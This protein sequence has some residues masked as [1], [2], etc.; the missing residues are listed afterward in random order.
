MTTAMLRAVR[1]A[2]D[3]TCQPLT[4]PRDE[5]ARRAVLSTAVGGAPEYAHYGCLGRGA[6]CAVVHETGRIDGLPPNWPATGFVARVRGGPLSY[7]LHGPVVL[8]G[9]DPYT[10]H[11]AD[12]SDEDRTAVEQL[13]ARRR[14][15]GAPHPIQDAPTT[16]AG[17]TVPRP[18]PHPRKT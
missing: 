10:G 18:A 8:L 2:P 17:R 6:V 16:P 15:P 4:V 9:F 3:G 11:L 5:E 12:L 7:C 13:A 1:V 14:T